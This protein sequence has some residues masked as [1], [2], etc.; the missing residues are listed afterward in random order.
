MF[1]R[2]SVTVVAVR[3][4]AIQ[5]IGIPFQILE[6]LLRSHS[7]VSRPMKAANTYSCSWYL[8]TPVRK[9]KSKQHKQ[10]IIRSKPQPRKGKPFS[11]IPAARLGLLVERLSAEKSQVR[12]PGQSIRRQQH[13]RV[14]CR[15]TQ[16]QRPRLPWT[17]N[18]HFQNEAKC[19]TFV[20]KI[21]FIC[22]RI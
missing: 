8:Q 9:N 1:I 18:S 13:L 10:K 22:M 21:S 2:Q 7:I 16:K 14:A 17:K 19:K 11:L 15:S 4:T 5:K 20:G 3:K 12:F 6:T